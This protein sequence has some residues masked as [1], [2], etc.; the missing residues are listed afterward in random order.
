M[1]T[2]KVWCNRKD[3]FLAERQ[4]RYAYNDDRFARS[5]Q[6]GYWYAPSSQP[7]IT[8]PTPI[9]VLNAFPLCKTA[10]SDVT[11]LRGLY[12]CA[13]WLSA[14]VELL[15]MSRS[16]CQSAYIVY[17]HGICDDHLSIKCH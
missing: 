11:A 13:P 12:N 1:T 17:L 9:W 4:L 16:T 8:F 3:G 14:G 7:L 2:Y 6:I 15:A 5:I 10:K